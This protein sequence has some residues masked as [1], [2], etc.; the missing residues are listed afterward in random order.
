MKKSI[1]FSVVAASVAFAFGAS[2]A[3]FAAKVPAGVKLDPKQELVRSNG[4]EPESLDISQIETT[5]ANN[6]ARDLFEG[7][8]AVENTGKIVPG[9]AVSWKQKDPTT[10][11]F[12]LR[13][14][15]K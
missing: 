10:W 2:G 15:A 6:I 9:V 11:I 3:A 8:T 14:D 7:L 5:T 12:N 13:K 4:S 1:S